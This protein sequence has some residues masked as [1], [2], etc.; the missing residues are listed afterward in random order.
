MK[1]LVR[2]VFSSHISCD[3]A[4]ES[5]VAW[6]VQM[7]AV[8]I[9]SAFHAPAEQAKLLIVQHSHLAEKLWSA[10]NMDHMTAIINM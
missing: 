2:S 3:E 9:I 1:P 10:T 7:S 6:L 8:D 4:I 5:Y